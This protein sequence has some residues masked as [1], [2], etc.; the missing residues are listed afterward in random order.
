[1]SI[2]QVAASTLMRGGQGSE[3][4]GLRIKR[5]GERMNVLIRDL[6][7]A[8]AIDA[9]RLRIEPTQQ[10]VG[11]LVSQA[12]ELFRPL[13]DEKHIGLTSEV[14]VPTD[15][16]WC[17]RERIVQVLSNLL[18]NAIKFTRK[19]GAITVRVVED[20]R[21]A[22]FAVTDTGCGIAQE[23]LLHVFDRYWHGRGAGPGVG[24]GLAIAKGIVEAHHGAIHA[25]STQGNGSTF[26]FELPRTA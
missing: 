2:I 12:I 23:Q 21:A 17:D 26:V 9:G 7:D 19:G 24:L 18:D 14:A 13:T 15:K 20:D 11:P 25:E 8:S 16:V 3:D 10:A 4:V 1:L 22:K 6:L 5:A